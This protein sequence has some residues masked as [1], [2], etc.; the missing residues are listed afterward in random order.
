MGALEKLADG[1][2]SAFNSI[3]GVRIYYK[4]ND[5]KLIQAGII[6]LLPL[7]TAY[8]LD[9][10]K[11][12]GIDFKVK[13]QNYPLLLFLFLVVTLYVLVEPK[14]TQ[15]NSTEVVGIVF[16]SVHIFA[17]ALSI[18]LI[19]AVIL[20]LIGATDIIQSLISNG[21][22]RF[23]G[24]LREPVFAAI[25]GLPFLLLSVGLIVRNSLR[26]YHAENRPTA[27][28]VRDSLFWRTAVLVT[29]LAVYQYMA[30]ILVGSAAG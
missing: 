18:N 23:A 5:I 16:L 24:E 22:T 28:F 8:L 29:L 19:Y 1:F 11:G 12:F 7:M 15:K 10:N 25:Y 26:T 27:E 21:A 14:I 2:S 20:Q 17:F 6:M 4:D 3:I 9:Y 13:L 30:F